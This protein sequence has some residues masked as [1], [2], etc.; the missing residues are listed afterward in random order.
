MRYSGAMMFLSDTL[1]EEE[2]GADVDGVDQDGAERERGAAE[3]ICR[4]LNCTS[5]RLTVAASMAHMT[6]KWVEEGKGIEKWRKILVKTEGKMSLSWIVISLNTS[7]RERIKYEG[8]SIVRCSN[9]EG[10]N[11]ARGSVIELL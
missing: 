5:L 6:E 1:L 9:K 2:E 8:K 7:I 4:D 10:K 11:Q 3:S